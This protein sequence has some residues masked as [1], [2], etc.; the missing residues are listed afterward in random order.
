MPNPPPWPGGRS[1][2]VFRDEAA[3]LPLIGLLGLFSSGCGEVGAGEASGS[4]GHD[5]PGFLAGQEDGE[6]VSRRTQAIVDAPPRETRTIAGMMFDIG[7]GPPDEDDLRN[8][9]IDSASSL[10]AAYREISYG[11][12]DLDIDLLGPYSLPE[13]TCLPIECCGPKPSQPNG[14][15]VADI[16]AGLPMEY[17]HY[18]WLY[19]DQP[20]G[21]N[22]GSW[23]DE[24]SAQR[25][26][27]YSSY[28]FGGLTVYAQ[29]LGHNFGMTHEPILR[30][31]PGGEMM[32][33]Q[34][35][36]CQH[37]EYGSTLSFMGRG[38]GHPS[39]YHKVQEGWL[40]GC[41]AVTVG[42][43]DTFTLLPLEIPCDG[44]QVLQVPAP[45]T[46]SA[47]GGGQGRAPMLSYYYLEL[48]TPQGLDARINGLQP[49]VV[50]SIGADFAGPTTQG[51]PYCY[52]LDQTPNDSL[53]NAGLKAGESFDDPA[54]GLTISV[55]QISESSA[56]VTIEMS[57][58]GSHSCH[59]GS[60]LT[61][62]GPDASSCVDGIGG[63]GGSGT[64]GGSA[65]M[66]G[67]SAGQGGA[68]A[69]GGGAGGM[70]GAGASGAAG[71]G[72]GGMSG[73]G[74]MAG[75]S[76]GGSAGMSGGGATATGGTA[77]TGGTMVAT[78]G[79]MPPATGGT[80]PMGGTPATGGA[81]GAAGTSPP[82]AASPNQVDGGCGCRVV[83][84]SRRGTAPLLGLLVLGAAARRRRSRRRR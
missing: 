28:S 26:A 48:R 16:I 36:Q 70:A 18:F 73:G 78:T 19:G 12:Q 6:G 63:A 2:L 3:L 52:V 13:Q 29:E 64:T 65:G 58:S 72:M 9:L 67:A 68:G 40:S 81:S 61:A 74:G 33:D 62:P 71:G 7:G 24:G 60:M 21:A 57:G 14:P 45:T 8:G 75:S 42:S 32:P 83:G 20:P 37:E 23:G 11:M 30:N 55:G 31:C 39:A 69:A 77:G 27:V 54:G 43:S 41:N 76:S 56:E 50:V 53:S 38:Q 80:S 15:A 82:V 22:C 44:I 35:S 59:D 79:G 49:M 66:G 5:E 4:R 34:P 51:S 1:K 25:P 46:R 84:S 10:R 47:P 17:D